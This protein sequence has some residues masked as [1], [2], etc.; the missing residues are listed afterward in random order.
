[1]TA[2]EVPTEA[3]LTATAEA[4]ELIAARALGAH[5]EQAARLARAHFPNVTGLELRVLTDPEDA[6][7]SLVLNVLTPA[8]AREAVQQYLQFV[9]AWIL[10]VPP[11]VQAEIV[12]TFCGT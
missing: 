11:A 6:T 3:Q 2:T 12:V 5:V 9:D 10:A 4:R 7:D 1:M 8:R